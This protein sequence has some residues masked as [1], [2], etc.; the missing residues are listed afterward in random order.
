MNEILK[1]FPQLTENQ[2]DKF[3]KM[4]EIY[5]FWNE[6]INVVSRKDIDFLYL[7][8]VLHS[9]SVAKVL[10]FVDKTEIVDVGTGGGFPGIPLA[11]LF[12]NVKF[13][14]VDSIKKKIKVVEAVKKELQLSNVECLSL[15][16]EGIF[17]KFDF[18][19]SRAVTKIYEFV[20]LVRHLVHSKHKNEFAN[21][22]FYLK[23]GDFYTELEYVNAKISIISISHFF[24]EDFFAEKK[25]IHLEF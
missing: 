9:L 24:E 16:S 10:G 15:R 21:G 3:A 17:Q 12:P 20:P 23:G 14:L 8:H 4:Q 1:Y 18:V 25:I 7:H 22:I 11:I 5:R 13:T 6:K 19:I 2:R